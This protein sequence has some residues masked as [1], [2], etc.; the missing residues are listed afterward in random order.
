[1]KIILKSA[2]GTEQILCDGHVVAKDKHIGPSGQS[3]SAPIEVQ[4]GRFLRA[5]NGR[6]L[7]RGNKIVRGSFS[8][9][10][11]CASFLAAEKFC[12]TYQ[13]DVLREGSL[14]I[15]AEDSAGGTEKLTLANTTVDDVR[16]VQIG[17]TVLITYTI[18]GGALT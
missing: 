13:R 4:P 8:V 9:T 7:N 14:I 5:I 16:C 15:L 17:V 18:S 2:T 1:M 12:W 10:R 3:L 6:P 11:E